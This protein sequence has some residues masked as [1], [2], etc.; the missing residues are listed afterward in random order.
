MANLL[1]NIWHNGKLVSTQIRRFEQGGLDD[2][3]FD[4]PHRT[5]QRFAING[6]G[7]ENPADTLAR[8]LLDETEAGQ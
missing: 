6:R 8:M 7:R 5:A 3:R 1:G 2:Y 4:S